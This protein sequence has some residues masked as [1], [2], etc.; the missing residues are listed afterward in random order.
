MEGGGDLRIGCA[1]SEKTS[2]RTFK[3]EYE[4]LRQFVEN[5]KVCR[6]L[7]YTQFNFPAV[8]N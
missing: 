8:A 7:T 6:I 5:S 1:M 4:A 2:I 3:S